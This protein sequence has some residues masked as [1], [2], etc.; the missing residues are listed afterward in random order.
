MVPY[1]SITLLCGSALV[2]AIMLLAPR[3]TVSLAACELAGEWVAANRASLPTTLDDFST[4]PMAHRRA[5][6][7]EL[8]VEDRRS[9]WREHLAT[10]TNPGDGLT[11]DQIATVMAIANRTGVYITEDPAVGR[12]ALEADGWTPERLTEAFGE[13]AVEVFGTLGPGPAAPAAAQHPD[14]ACSV[15]SDWCGSS[16]CTEWVCEYKITGCGTLWCFPCDGL[17]YSGD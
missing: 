9:L 14:C 8:S 1:R 13:R 17:C 2:V 16:T 10:F 11:G 3:P 12:A 15:D 4:L 6:Y 7:A 5:V